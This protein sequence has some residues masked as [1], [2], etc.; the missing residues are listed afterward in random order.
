MSTVKTR[1]Y[2]NFAKWP[3]RINS[4]KK[5]FI[6]LKRDLLFLLKPIIAK[7]VI[8]VITIANIVPGNQ[9]SPLMQTHL[10]KKYKSPKFPLNEH[11]HR[12]T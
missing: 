9:I 2:I 12:K 4:T 1:N 8:A 6:F 11:T 3:L 10:T 5:I 7:E